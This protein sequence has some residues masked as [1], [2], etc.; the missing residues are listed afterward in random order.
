[1]NL[2]SPELNDFILT[3]NKEE[4]FVWEYSIATAPIAGMN[5]VKVDAVRYSRGNL[6]ITFDFQGILT[7]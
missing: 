7:L 5:V 1:M 6:K 3:V 4:G 2:S